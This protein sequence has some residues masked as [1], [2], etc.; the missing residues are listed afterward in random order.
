MPPKLKPAKKVGCWSLAG[1][2]VVDVDDVEGESE[3]EGAEVVGERGL[4]GLLVVL[5]VVVESRRRVG[6]WEKA[7]RSFWREREGERRRVGIVVVGCWLFG[8]LG[9][10]V[11]GACAEDCWL[12]GWPRAVDSVDFV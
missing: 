9:G 8:P 1:D 2:V 12:G 6:E 5:V 11:M 10:G 3:G 7:V 4:V